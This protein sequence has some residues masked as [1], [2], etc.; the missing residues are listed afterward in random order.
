M[1]S[2][3]CHK[4]SLL[5]AFRALSVYR[6]LVTFDLRD[7][8]SDE[9]GVGRFTRPGVGTIGTGALVGGIATGALIVGGINA[10]IRESGNGDVVIRSSG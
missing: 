5:G 4:S 6:R 10:S 7:T 3:V 8:C 9:R 1:K 2:Q